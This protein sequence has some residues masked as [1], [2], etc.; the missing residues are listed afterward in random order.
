MLELPQ[1]PHAHPAVFLPDGQQQGSD[2]IVELRNRHW[3][4]GAQEHDVCTTK[5]TMKQTQS[6]TGNFQL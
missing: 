6:I 3:K 5:D 1:G 2:R 4:P